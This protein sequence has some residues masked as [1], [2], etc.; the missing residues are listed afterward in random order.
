[1]LRALF[2]SRIRRPQPSRGKQPSH[3]AR[4]R[5]FFEPLED[6]RLM[7]VGVS[8]A[9][10]VLTFTGDANSD[11][12]LLQSTATTNTVQY[13]AGGLGLTTQAGVT[14]VVYN[15][16][17][18]NDVLVVANPGGNIFAP[19]A[20]IVFNGGGQAGDELDL[21]GGAAS[22][23]G[24]Y[25]VATP[26]SGNISYTDGSDT[27]MVSFSGIPLVRDSMTAASL[28]TNTSAAADTINVDKGPDLGGIASISQG[29]AFIDGGDRDDHG[30][31]NGVSNVN[32]WLFMQQGLTFLNSTVFNSG[33]PNSV[34]AIGVTAGQAMNAL[35]SAASAAVSM[36][37]PAGLNVTVVTGAAIDTVNF[38][39]YKI[40]YVPSDNVDTVG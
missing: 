28:T 5:A 37:A 6:R 2:G 15:G 40:I 3:I 7:T 1:M 4:R 39:N 20:G 33:A 18:G 9:A 30:S 36:A 14:Q 12:V 34:L 32:G 17:G 11:T 26:T 31:F 38:N 27:Q 16:N 24:T 8:F 29:P 19:S 13:N 25:N 21:V 23:T 22:W 10:G 35:N